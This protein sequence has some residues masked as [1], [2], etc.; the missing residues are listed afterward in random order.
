MKRSTK[1]PIKKVVSGLLSGI[2]ALALFFS[3]G[4]QPAAAQGSSDSAQPG[5][6]I[7]SAQCLSAPMAGSDTNASTGL[8]N[9]VGTT[10]GHPIH[11]LSALPA[12]V[13]PEGAARAY[14]TGCGSLFG[15]TSQA[16]QLAL[17]QAKPASANRSVLKFQQVYQGLPVFGAVLMVQLD[18]AKNVIMVNGDL[19]PASKIDTQASVDAAAAQ[20]T[21]L[22]LVAKKYNTTA[23]ALK[24]SQPQLSIYDPALLS[25]AGVPTLAWR[26]DVTPTATA[27]I[28]ELVMV[29]AHDGSVVLNFNQID[30]ALN[31][32]TY[33]A[34]N[35]TSL[36]G[37]LL[38]TES[39]PTCVGSGGDTDAINAQV[40]GGDTYNYYFNNFDR[41]SL[42]NAGMTLIST[43]HYDYGYCNAFWDN[44]QMV[45]G[46]NTGTSGCFI[47][48]D[49]VV[50]HEMTHG[51]TSHE[52][53]LNYQDQSGA[54]N[55]SLSDI[56]GEFMDLTNGHGNDAPSVRW[57][58]GEDTSVGAIRNMQNPP[59]Y[60]QPDRM[61]SSL[62]YTGTDDNG[63][64]HTNS[65]VGNKAAYL[66]TDGD[67]FNGYTVR[68]L[69]IQK[70]GSIFYEAQTSILTPTSNYAALANALNQACNILIGTGG[71]VADDCTQVYY[72]T[73]ATQMQYPPLT[74][75]APSG[76]TTIT[77]PT[78]KWTKSSGATQYRYQLVK[79]V[80]TTIYIKT[81]GAAAP[82]CGPAYCTSKPTVALAFG[83][84]KWR[85]QAKVG[86]VWTAYSAYKGFS[87]GPFKPNAGYW[88]GSWSEFYVNPGRTLVNKFAIYV[89]VSGCGSY[90]ITHMVS[91]PIV[92]KKFAFSGPFYASGTFTSLTVATGKAGLSHFPISGC[93][94]VSGGPYAWTHTWQHA[95]QA[96]FTAEKDAPANIIE[97]ASP[98][99]DF[100]TVE[101]VGP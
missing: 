43:V 45:Y 52:S 25:K 14:L 21:A 47:V 5:D 9:F 91:A 90:K 6:N 20:Q 78:Y 70:A 13:S 73:L 100:I 34:N 28:R 96:T 87:V 83:S 92:S 61:G 18:A 55:E 93:G 101:K 84:Y 26:M 95:L 59:A 16:D 49:D 36:P 31:R 69:G 48:A 12:S 64:V 2:A 76:A 8:V 77:L 97:P 10:A 46:D 53:N 42:D 33:T 40:Y 98:D 85:V 56:F 89:Y 94:T 37:S 4:G 27:P 68:G 74:P 86:G 71:I 1:A 66:I 75:I 22:S 57:L 29:D 88:S 32:V 30:T 54:I 63:G 24:T 38:C 15:L 60:G 72:A 65:G 11:Q 50:G 17:M 82:V 79:G 58:M 7:A 23:A 3:A 81:I 67:T 44:T 80:A 51:V 35:S 99:H 19:S 39:D 62:Y 41:N